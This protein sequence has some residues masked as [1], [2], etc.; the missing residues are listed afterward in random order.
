[1]SRFVMP[2]NGPLL[3]Y[4]SV[5]QYPAKVRVLPPPPSLEKKEN[6]HPT[7][8]STKG[9]P[10]HNLT[11]SA[12][13]SPEHHL[14]ASAKE[15]KAGKFHFT[16]HQAVNTTIP[17]PT[18]EQ[19]TNAPTLNQKIE[20]S[21]SGMAV[22]SVDQNGPNQTNIPLQNDK[23]VLS[24]LPPP[25]PPPPLQ[26]E[27]QQM[28][29]DYQPPYYPIQPQ[30]PFQDGMIDD[31]SIHYNQ[32][33]LQDRFQQ[34]YINQRP[35]QNQQ[36]FNR[37]PIQLDYFQPQTQQFSYEPKVIKDQRKRLAQEKRKAAFKL[38]PP[39]GPWG[40]EYPKLE[41]LFQN[42]PRIPI[43][44]EKKDAKILSENEGEL[45][46]EVNNLNIQQE[47]GDQMKLI[48][49]QDQEIKTE[50]GS[51]VMNAEDINSFKQ[52]AFGIQQVGAHP[53]LKE[54]TSDHDRFT[55]SMKAINLF[56]YYLDLFPG[57]KL[58]NKRFRAKVLPS[59]N[60][61]T[62]T[63]WLSN[64]IFK[65]N[66][67]LDLKLLSQGDLAYIFAGATVEFEIII[68]E[69]PRSFFCGINPNIV[70]SNE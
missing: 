10:E 45:S 36:S 29:S 33:L 37:N 3:P 35:Y 41:P 13:G 12:K 5:L 28:I 50:S 7:V 46:S 42:K 20:Q 14:S 60:M 6:V 56:E 52:K 63:A 39:E 18:N 25:P 48:S 40:G 32:G 54:I 43:I 8:N 4:G 66:V 16:Q 51:A 24:Q 68:N 62:M 58:D 17:T 44:I 21:N 65:D 22:I 23:A 38:L 15:F 11:A 55:V 26:Y 47:L 27:P 9:G 49:D 70:Y 31:Y 59:L 69:R 64:N 61:A 34:L 67:Y 19:S 2:L 53:R 1:M 57:L 30:I